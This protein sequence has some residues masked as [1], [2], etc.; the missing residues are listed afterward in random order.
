[1]FD[2]VVYTPLHIWKCRKER[3][4]SETGKNEGKKNKDRKK[5]KMKRNE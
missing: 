1:M 4:K 5:T 2:R 3:K